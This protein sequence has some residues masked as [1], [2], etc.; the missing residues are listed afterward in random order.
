[1]LLRK[2]VTRTE[3]ATIESR[4]PVYRINV[5]PPAGLFEIKLRCDTL[6][7]FFE[8]YRPTLQ[9]SGAK[10]GPAL[11]GVDERYVN[12]M[13]QFALFGAPQWSPSCR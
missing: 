7:I 12:D 8:Q 5:A 9:F 13:R 1:M 4:R 3:Y 6:K 10:R 2:S 11:T